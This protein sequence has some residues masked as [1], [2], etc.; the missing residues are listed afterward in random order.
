MRRPL[1]LAL[2]CAAVALCGAQALLGDPLLDD[3]RLVPLRR[4]FPMADIFSQPA[5]W[6]PAVHASF[7]AVAALSP[8]NFPRAVLLHHLVSAA[9]HL[10]AVGLLV[11]LDAARRPSPRVHPWHVAALTAFALHPSLV[12]VWGHLSGRGE[13]IALA[14]LAGLAL[15]LHHGAVAL[16]AMLAFLGAAASPAAGVAA[17]ALSAGHALDEPSPRA[18]RAALAVAAVA[19]AT[20]PLAWGPR[21]TAA[22]L[23]RWAARAPAAVSVV[24]RSLLVPSETALRLPH[25]ELSRPVTASGVAFAA[26]PLLVAGLLW[27]RGARGACVRV[28]GAAACA[29]PLAAR[30]DTLAFGIDRYVAAP[31]VLCAVTLLLA[32]PPAWTASLST[33]ARRL[34]G[35]AA[36]GAALLLGFMVQQTAAGFV[37]DAHQLDAMMLMRPRDPSGHLRNAWFA[38]RTGDHAS[39]LRGLRRARRAPL[40]PL[41]GRVA[42]AIARVSAGW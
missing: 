40:T 17:V 42:Q 35:A 24:T 29:L 12:E 39:T 2:L 1:L 32:P 27:R 25:W 6:Q 20:A 33:T 3:L 28:L 14:S 16:P 21:P 34:L 13:A 37:S 8:R 5:R 7:R 22:S 23:L 9:L 11:R 4:P 18:R 31:A 38:A 30:A 26:L 19:L 36:L 15:A 10:L 41:M